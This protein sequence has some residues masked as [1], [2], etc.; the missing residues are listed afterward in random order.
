[1]HCFKN[2]YYVFNIKLVLTSAEGEGLGVQRVEF[3]FMDAL[4]TKIQN[5][6]I[7]SFSTPRFKVEFRWKL[8]PK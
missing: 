5:A 7:K 8:K 1:M 3:P 6:V 2:I 4:Y